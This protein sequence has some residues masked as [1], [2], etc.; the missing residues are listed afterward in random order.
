MDEKEKLS[1]PVSIIIA[2][3]VIALAIILTMGSKNGVAKNQAQPEASKTQEETN[4][5]LNQA[6]KVTEQDHIKGSLGAPIKIITYSDFECPFCKNFHN[7]MNQIM[8]EYGSGG[9]VAW[10]YRQF[11]L[12]SLHPV[13]ALL[14]AVTSECI[15]QVGGNNAFWAFADA[16]FAVTPSN[17]RTELD[18]VLPK[19]VNNL[20]LSQEKI[21]ECVK[22]GKYDQH[23]QDDVDEAIATGGRGTPWSILVTEN[24]KQYPINGAQS[25]ATVKA[26]IDITLKEVK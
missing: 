11:P 18:T 23:I 2:G 10:V 13:K 4:L 19:I 15:S 22:S 7:T 5:S 16:F 6:S 26:L 20:G 12:D 14:E 24:G 8:E 9:K 1:I 3:V 25:Y 21:D 17:N